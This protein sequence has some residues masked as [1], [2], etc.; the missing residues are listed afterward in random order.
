MK[1]IGTVTLQTN[2]LILRK[3]QMNDASM[4][5]NNYASDPLVT[6]YLTWKHHADVSTTKEILSMWINS[7]DNLKNY[8]WAIVLKDINEVIGGISIV[9]IDEVNDSVE[10]GY[11]LSRKYWNCGYTTEALKEVIR[12]CF[13]VIGVKEVTGRFAQDNIASGK[14]MEKCGMIYTHDTLARNNQKKY[15]VCKNYSIKRK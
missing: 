8:Q 6:K 7:Y 5:Y 13:E 4:M 2:R 11:C 15:V 10:V 14:V 3:F 1:H 12:F 9:D